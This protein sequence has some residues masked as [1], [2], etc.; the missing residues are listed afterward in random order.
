MA[1]NVN[2]PFFVDVTVLNG[3]R[4]EPGKINLNMVMYV[5]RTI[6]NGI[7]DEEKGTYEKDFATEVFFF[8][9]DSIRIK[10][11]IETV[12]A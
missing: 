6:V 7:W 2:I 4:E 3:T 5:K 10:D 8:D 12:D 9:G 11:D 1:A